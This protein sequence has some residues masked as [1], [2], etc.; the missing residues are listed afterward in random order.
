M[1]TLKSGAGAQFSA[2]VLWLKEM[3][4]PR[5]EKGTYNPL[6]QTG[7]LN[8]FK[9]PPRFLPPAVETGNAKAKY[10]SQHKCD[11]VLFSSYLTMLIF[12]DYLTL[13]FK[14]VVS[15]SFF[16]FL[17]LRAKC[18]KTIAIKTA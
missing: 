2:G 16:K 4:Q 6:Q 11:D 14:P 1:I 9:H 7:A 5:A 3:Q 8:D 18:H 13:A 10:Y 15:N 12:D 17:L